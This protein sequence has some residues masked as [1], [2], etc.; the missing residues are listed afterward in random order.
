MS[1]I[2]LVFVEYKK[3]RRSHIGLLLL[4]AT[5]ILW[6][7]S[8]LHADLNF[9]MQA[10]GISPE[11]NFFIQGFMGLYWF[12]FPSSMV[13]VTV[14]LNQTERTNR[15]ILKMLSLPVSTVKLCL[16]KFTV[17]VSLAALQLLLAILAYAMS[18]KIASHMQDY[19]FLLPPTFLCKETG[20]AFL[21]SVP[22]LA[23]FWM[24]AVC[25]RM[26]ICS[27]GLGLAMVAPSVLAINTKAWFLYPPAYPFYVLSSEYSRLA[28]GLTDFDIQL[29]P[30]VPVAAL[31]TAA[32]LGV[33]CLCFGRAKRR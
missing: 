30:W 9:K 27:I 12:L 3:I 33:S 17:L 14:L 29:L 23:L 10:E 1:F 26:P 13:V 25:I 6:V 24:L 4:A 31:L 28:K 19:S 5:I 32:C 15:G 20:M 2:R 21:S 16:A 8:L 7:P 11:H 22:M 18:A